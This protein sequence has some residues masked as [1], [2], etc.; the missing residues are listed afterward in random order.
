MLLGYGVSNYYCFKEG[1]EIDFRL[2]KGCPESISKGKNYTNVLCV[3]GANG[4][5]KSYALRAL[6][7]LAYFCRNS[8]S[9]K[10]ED[11]FDFDTFYSNKDP[12]SFYIEFA[13][14][15][16]VY[17]YELELFKDRILKEILYKKTNRKTKVFEREENKIIYRNN[18]YKELDAIKLRSNASIISTAHQYELG[19]LKGIYFFFLGI[20]GLDISNMLRNQYGLELVSD[21]YNKDSSRFG[22]TRDILLKCDLG[23]K[24]VRL[25]ERIDES[26][27]KKFYP[28]FVHEVDDKEYILHYNKESSGTISLYIQLYAYKT[29]LDF[30]GVLVMDEF[31][32]NLHPDILPI[33]VNFFTDETINTND[34]Q[35]I[36]NTH[37]SGIMDSLGKYR[38]ILVNK[39]QNESFLYRLDEL[40]GDMI[41]NDRPIEPIYKS[42]KIGGVPRV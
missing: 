40:P 15:G 22:F 36:F 9:Y 42:G 6:H 35:L 41:R 7:F 1:I 38:T 25:E 20:L 5:G 21:E 39:E 29:V 37:N 23:I 17:L 12:A 13:L 2:G 27:I 30:G 19:C 8:F 33:L 14:E 4:S 26:G 18:Q 3:K 28:V 10:P 16:I 11:T 31:D 34:A 24:D 32:I